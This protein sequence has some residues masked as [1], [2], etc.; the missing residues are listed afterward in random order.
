MIVSVEHEDDATWYF[1]PVIA[2]TCAE[3]SAAIIALSLPA[4][5]AIFGFM[6]E[7]RSTKGQSESNGSAGVAL[8]SVPRKRPRIFHGSDTYENTTEIDCG[9]NAS[10]EALWDREGDQKIRI[11]ETVDVEVRGLQNWPV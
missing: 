2:W 11:T 10:Q 3:I 4:L 1:S 7:H 6:K 8:D 5:R 9:R